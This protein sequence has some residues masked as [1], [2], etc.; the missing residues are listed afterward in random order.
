MSYATVHSI[1]SFLSES[2]NL[3]LVSMENGTRLE[4]SVIMMIWY[5]TCGTRRR[6]RRSW[7]W[8]SPGESPSSPW[9]GGFL[10]LTG[11]PSPGLAR[12]MQSLESHRAPISLFAGIT[13]TF[14]CFVLCH[15]AGCHAAVSRSVTRHP[16][17]DVAS[18]C[19]AAILS[20]ETAVTDPRTR[21]QT[22]CSCVRTVLL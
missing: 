15:A 20:A 14:C 1:Y 16:G 7:G 5:C 9:H 6:M 21:V 3:W 12:G 4:T 8:W 11:H 2:T 13:N 19:D 17:C 10:T 22:G 18:Y